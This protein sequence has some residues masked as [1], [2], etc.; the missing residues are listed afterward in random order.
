MN[1]KELIEKVRSDLFRI[2]R[3]NDYKSLWK[4]LFTNEGFKYVFWFRIYHY[5]ISV[6][7]LRY[8]LRFFVRVIYRH[9]TYKLGIS[10]PGKTHIGKGLKINHFSD[11]V[12][13]S[14]CIIGDN[15]TISNGVTIGRSDR[16]DREGCPIIGNGI[17]IGPGAK[18]FGNI[19]IGNNVAIG[20][21]AVVTKDIEDNGVAVGIPAKVVSYKGAVEYVKNPCV[22]D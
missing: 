11:I 20:A 6:K 16:G 5:T 3:S 13:N 19:T 17:Y 15:L 10:I 8:S 22:E 14:E 1:L 7:A 4:A 2:D 9:Y 21:N 12:I 18:V